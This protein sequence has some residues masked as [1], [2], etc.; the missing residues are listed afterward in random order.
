MSAIDS[1]DKIRGDIEGLLADHEALVALRK[2]LDGH[3]RV[4]NLEKLATAGDGEFIPIENLHVKQL[5]V[6]R[7]KGWL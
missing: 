6:A 5:V 4:V 3:R 1:T 7:P 2:V